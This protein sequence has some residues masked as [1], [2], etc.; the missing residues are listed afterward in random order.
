MINLLLQAHRQDTLILIL[1]QVP[2]ALH[3][4]IHVGAVRRKVRK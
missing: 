4:Q 2:E 3:H 1:S